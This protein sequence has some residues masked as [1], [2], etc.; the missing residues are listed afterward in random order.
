MVFVK[1]AIDNRTEIYSGLLDIC[2][3]KSPKT[4]PRKKS[5]SLPAEA[6]ITGIFDYDKILT[7]SSRRISTL[8]KAKKSRIIMANTGNPDGTLDIRE[9]GNKVVKGSNLTI[10]LFVLNI[11]NRVYE[12]NSSRDCGYGNEHKRE[13]ALPYVRIWHKS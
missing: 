2:R 5:K 1:E 3:Q 4:V 12:R 7:K 9:C 13:N 6:V 10:T 8:W 11:T